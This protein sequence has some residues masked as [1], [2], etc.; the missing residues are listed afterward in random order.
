MRVL[1]S[2]LCALFLI[3]PVTAQETAPETGTGAN[4]YLD[5]PAPELRRRIADLAP[6]HQ[7]KWYRVEVLVFARNNP[8][9]DEFWRLD[10]EPELV[11]NPLIPGP[12]L[13]ELPEEAGEVEL[14]AAEL[15]AWQYLV[16]QDY[17]LADMLERMNNRGDYRVLFHQ[18]WRQPV[19]EKNRAFSLRI[20]GGDRLMPV[21]QEVDT[22]MSGVDG[23]GE[24]PVPVDAA[25]E[26]DVGPETSAADSPA[27]QDPQEDGSFS[28]M[29]GDLKLY[30]SRYLHVEPNLWYTDESAD[31]QRFNVV[32]DQ[33]RRMR[34]EELHYIDHPLFGLLLYLEP[35][36][37]EKQKQAELMEQALEKQMER[38]DG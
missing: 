5:T 23:F 21:E 20:Q 18:H 24:E 3:S 27:P 6:V 11:A 33:R 38:D 13:P 25:P 16:D 34:S 4:P 26:T 7:E 28:E 32:I 1:L 37:T 17:L 9:T 22:L 19:R 29:R 8:V 14:A 12:E 36:Q 10:R 30:L 15:G 2:G 31:G 35:W